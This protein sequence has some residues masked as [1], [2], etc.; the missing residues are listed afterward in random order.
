MRK[1]LLE[2]ISKLSRLAMLAGVLLIATTTPGATLD[3]AER[4]VFDAETRLL[5]AWIEAERAAWVKANFITEDTEMIEAEAREKLLALTAE[6]A[7]EST[8]FDALKLPDELRRKI[9]LIKTS[10]SSVAPRDPAKQ[11]ELARITSAMESLYGRGTYCSPARKGE[12][13]DLTAMVPILAESRNADELLDLWVG[14]RGVSPPMRRMFTRFVELANEGAQELGFADLGELWRSN[15]DMP[16]D[17]FAEEVDRLWGQVQT[18]VRGAALSRAGQ[19][20]RDLRRASW[21][22]RTGRSRLICWATCGANP[23]ATSTTSFSPGESDPGYEVTELL[24]AKQLDAQEMVRHGERFFTSLGFEPLPDTFWERS[25]FT[26]PA[27]RDVVCHAS[28]WDL[29]YVDDLRIKMCIDITEEDFVTIHHE[30]GHNFY[31]RAYAGQSPLHRNSAND[32][33]HEGIGDTVAL[34]ITPEYLVTARPARRGAGPG[35]RPR[36]A[37]ADGAGQGRVPALRPARRPVALEGLLRAR[38][39]RRRTTTPAG[40]SCARSYQ[41]IRPPVERSE[42]RLRP[43]RQVP[44]TGQRARTP[45][46]SWLTSCSSSSTAH[47]ARPPGLRG[48]AAPLLDLRQQGGRPAADPT[49][50]RWACQPPVARRAGGDDRPARDGR[51]GDPGLLRAAGGTGSTSRT[52]AGPAAGEETCQP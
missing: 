21:W 34:S 44:R 16:P 40:G 5:E 12:C 52:G 8:Q 23:G 46:T 33:F 45:G 43:G 29:D 19:A 14:W 10:L 2:A 11:S 27:D 36:P 25:L 1:Q 41:G 15:Y 51:H 18:P 42:S 50:S 24:A 35:R 31:Q 3:E 26:K 4:F 47:C 49:C 30:L 32:G 20:C 48:S 6:L 28:A 13:L 17:E 39:R 38:S 37:D 9:R 7:A 22:P